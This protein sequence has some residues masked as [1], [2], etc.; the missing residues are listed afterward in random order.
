MEE[1]TATIRHHFPLMKLLYSDVMK[2]YLY[3]I[4]KCRYNTHY[5]HVK[6]AI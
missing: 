1:N 3:S 5:E 2:L 6:M 4:V